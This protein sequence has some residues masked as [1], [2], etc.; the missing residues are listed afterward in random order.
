MLFRSVSQSRYYHVEYG[1]G[2]KIWINKKWM[3][4][5]E[6]DDQKFARKVKEENDSISDSARDES[7]GYWTG[8]PAFDRATFEKMKRNVS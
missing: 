8:V 3:K 1:D 6:T 2:L 5:A 4:L 7:F